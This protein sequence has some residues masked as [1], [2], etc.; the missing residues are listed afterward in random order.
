MISKESTNYKLRFSDI[1]DRDIDQAIDYHS[2]RSEAGEY[3]FKNELNQALDALEINPFFQFRYKN[4]RAL[5]FKSLPY[6]IF[7]E[8][9]EQE[10]VVYIYAIFNT[11][12]N[13]NKYPNL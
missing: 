2:Q 9:E 8:V 11:H 3:N 10:K 12:Q 1:A 5:P 7:F 6:L 4:I 13:S